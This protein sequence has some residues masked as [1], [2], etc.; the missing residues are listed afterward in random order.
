MSMV[1]IP[2]T[3]PFNTRLGSIPLLGV[4]VYSSN[5]SGSLV[6]I[7]QCSSSRY[8]YL[9]GIYFGGGDMVASR[10][11]LLCTIISPSIFSLAFICTG[12]WEV[13]GPYRAGPITILLF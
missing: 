1:V 2:P 9:V 7:P 13:L 3:V 8:G 5:F 11:I 10:I 4:V 6:H 12:Y